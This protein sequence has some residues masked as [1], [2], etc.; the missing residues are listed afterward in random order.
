MTK[1]R[2]VGVCGSLQA[3]STN[4]AILD[5][6]RTRAPDGVEVAVFDSLAGIPAFNPDIDPAPPSVNEWR[7]CIRTADALLIAT[8]EYAYGVPGTLKNALDWLVG[9]GDLYG[10]TAAVVSAAPAPE[11][12]QHARADLE[13][14]VQ[15][16]GAVIAVSRTIARGDDAEIAVDEI[17]AALV[18]TL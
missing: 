12:G 1:T 7:N 14:T 18:S 10:K 4:R 9:S 5:L 17:V 16:Q 2:I 6:A 3:R 8:P 15:A 11:R 13:R